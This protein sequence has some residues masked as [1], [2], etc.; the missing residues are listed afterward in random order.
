MSLGQ[1]VYWVDRMG[2]S[3]QGNKSQESPGLKNVSTTV[4]ESKVSH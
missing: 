2:L 1:T 3:R 4:G